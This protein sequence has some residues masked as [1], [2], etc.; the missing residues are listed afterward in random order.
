MTMIVV[1]IKSNSSKRRKGPWGRKMGSSESSTEPRF[2]AISQI[3]TYYQG[4]FTRKHK[5]KQKFAETFF[6]FVR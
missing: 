5:Q 4:M 6:F 1:A 3:G 2:G